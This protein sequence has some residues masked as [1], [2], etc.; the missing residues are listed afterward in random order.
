MRISGSRD[1]FNSFK[2]S[3]DR[4]VGSSILRIEGNR[5]ELTSTSVHS[6][7]NSNRSC[8]IIGSFQHISY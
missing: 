4:F 6:N 7:L 5:G 3:N 1:L 8:H 2:V